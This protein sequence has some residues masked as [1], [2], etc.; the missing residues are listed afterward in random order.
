M[1]INVFFHLNDDF[2]VLEKRKFAWRVIFG[3]NFLWCMWLKISGCVVGPEVDSVMSFP[4]YKFWSRE[5]RLPERLR[6]F[7]TK[8]MT[9]T[10]EWSRSPFQVVAVQLQW[11]QKTK[12][13][14]SGEES[15][16]TPCRL[17]HWAVQSEH[18]AQSSQLTA[19]T[20]FVDMFC[21]DTAYYFWQWVY[22]CFFRCLISLI[23]NSTHVKSLYKPSD[24]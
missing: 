3:W 22:F 20:C 4:L 14:V 24:C 1:G 11:T 15:S 7:V 18:H 13:R 2:Q 5:T 9:S 10:G 8:T 19:F 23:V 12:F 16:P 6:C 21:S 17:A